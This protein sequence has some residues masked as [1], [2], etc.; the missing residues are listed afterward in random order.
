VLIQMRRGSLV[1]QEGERL[2]CA[3]LGVLYALQAS[4]FFAALGRG[5]AA[6]V[7]LVF[8]SYP[9]MVALAE[10]TRR[11]LRWSTRIAAAMALSIGGVL[12]VVAVEGKL[13]ITGMGVLFSLAAAMLF[14]LFTLAG[15]ELVHQTEAAIRALWTT[16]AATITL[17]ALAVLSGDRW[18]EARRLPELLGY[19]TATA[20]AFGLVFVAL[21]QIGPTR[22]SVILNF[23]VV[24]SVVLA[25]LLLGEALSPLQ[26]LGG[27]AVIAGAIL[28]ARA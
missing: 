19:G 22:T 13:S 24:T 27:T 20:A 7:S 1:P 4:M 14:A 28:A 26:A 16:G 23:E 5:S 15:K 25:A 8:Y 11:T 18:P 21:R 17:T 2:R 3:G 6:A 10:I 12:T 9:A